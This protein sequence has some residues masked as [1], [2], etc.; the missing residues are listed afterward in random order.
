MA[1]FNSPTIASI[2]AGFAKQVQQL[3]DL[4][5]KEKD[6]AVVHT[7]QGAE[8]IHK[9]KQ[10]KATAERAITLAGRLQAFTDV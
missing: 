2:T 3:E 7:A 5:A 6:N 8:L 4:S 10:A 1:M 9:G